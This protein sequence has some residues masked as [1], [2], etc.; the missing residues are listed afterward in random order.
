MTNRFVP[1]LALL[2]V[3]TLGACS[4]GLSP[5]VQSPDTVI[6]TNQDRGRDNVPLAPG[7]GAIAY[8]PDGCQGWIIDD[9]VEGYS[10][11]RFDPV[12]G[13]PVCNNHFPPGTVVRNY[14][15]RDAGLRDYVPYAGRRT[16]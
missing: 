9:G 15:T 12:S 16:N 5:Y 3:L 10:G 14:Q 8:D 7:G 11:R 6:A 1:G 13:L 4:D 2:A